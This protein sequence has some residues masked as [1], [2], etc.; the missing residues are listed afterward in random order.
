VTAKNLG[1]A[2][3]E[4][5]DEFA[6]LPDWEE[7]FRYVIE[8]AREL[9]PLSEAEHSDE[10]KV[11]GCASQVWLVSERDPA[12]QTHLRFRGDSDA[13]LVKGLIAILLRLYNDARPAD[14]LAFDIKDALERLELSQALSPQRS[15]GLA[16]MI[17][18]I[19]KEA[20]AAA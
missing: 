12:D 11:R 1:E 2:L 16:S 18:R 6:L 13:L 9:A 14:I 15:N 19:R 5:E 7:R 10:N 4:L 8:L 20:A 3:T 17:E